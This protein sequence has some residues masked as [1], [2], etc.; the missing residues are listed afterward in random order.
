M[1]AVLAAELRVERDG[2]H[3]ALTDGHRVPVNLGQHLSNGPDL[4]LGGAFTYLNVWNG[5]AGAPGGPIS[6]V[7]VSAPTVAGRSAIL[8]GQLGEAAQII[9]DDFAEA[10]TIT[11]A[12]TT[13][14]L[15][16]PHPRLFE[17]AFVLVPLNDIAPDRKISGVSVRDALAKVD[18]TGME[19]LPPR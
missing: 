19:R 1:D 6:S 11:E 4:G 5:H 12:A 18:A 2:D 10:A 14:V 3:R 15:T 17:R 8:V 7:T 16:L 9:G 13:P